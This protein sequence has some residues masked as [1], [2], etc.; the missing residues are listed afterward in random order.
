M[1]CGDTPSGSKQ[2][3]KK[4]QSVGAPQ[5][6]EQPNVDPIISDANPP[7]YQSQVEMIVNLNEVNDKGLVAEL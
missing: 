6:I 4:D 1:V 5:T 7:S 3:L 2:T